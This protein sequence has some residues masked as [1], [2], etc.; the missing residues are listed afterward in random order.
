MVLKKPSKA[1]FQNIS[2]ISAIGI[3]LLGAIGFIVSL[4]MKGLF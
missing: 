3:A 4:I 1:E 2:K